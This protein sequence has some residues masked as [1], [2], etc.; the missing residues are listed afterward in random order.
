MLLTQLRAL[1]PW[2]WD[3]NPR[4][5]S[6]HTLSR[7]VTGYPK[8]AH[9]MRPGNKPKPGVSDAGRTRWIQAAPL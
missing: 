5:L 6:L 7:T 1:K 3:L 8:V 4:K 2:L 9:L